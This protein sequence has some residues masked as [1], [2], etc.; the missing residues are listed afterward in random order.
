M[1]LFFF[2][3]FFDSKGLACRARQGFC[4]QMDWTN[5]YVRMR[6]RMWL[7]RYLRSSGMYL[8]IWRFQAVETKTC[9]RIKL[10]PIYS[11]ASPEHRHFAHSARGRDLMRTLDELG[12]VHVALRAGNFRFS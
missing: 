5:R 6:A 1:P 12:Y 9:M 7:R 10:H 11:P 3:S 8:D 2:F 4:R